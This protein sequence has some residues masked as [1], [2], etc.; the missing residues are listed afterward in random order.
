MKFKSLLHFLDYF[1]DERTCL[2]YFESTRWGNTPTCP[3]CKAQRPYV[4]SRGYRC[5]EC[6]RKFTAKIGTI[7][8]NSKVPM[9]KWFMAAYLMSS[10]KKGI[11]SV[12]LANHLGVTQKTAWFMLHRLREMMSKN[13]PQQL[14]RI[15]EVD[16]T[17]IGGLE[18]N[19]HLK[20]K[21][22]SKATGRAV[23]GTRYCEKQIVMGLVQRN[24]N[25]ILQHVPNKQHDTLN[26]TI[27]KYLSKGCMLVTDELPAYKMLNKEYN[28]HSVNHSECEYVRGQV[29]TNNVEG[30]FSN[31]KRSLHGIY[32]NVSPKH[33]QRYL[34]EFTARYNNRRLAPFEKFD[35]FISQTECGSIL[36][37]NL[38]ANK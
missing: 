23:D 12:Q 10:Q 21:S 25:I 37:K 7:Y 32:H 36:Y 29:Y 13:R 11:N 17:H 33:L 22:A 35:L 8:E 20:K 38:T 27:R 14:G 15:V 30:V 18:A 16:E 26:G 6:D 19:R 3:H 2:R 28:H 9:R 5:R 31:L 34:D 4:T 1:K 24:G